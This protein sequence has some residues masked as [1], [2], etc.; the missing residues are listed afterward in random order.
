MVLRGF[1][2]IPR[3]SEGLP[4]GFLPFLQLQIIAAEEIVAV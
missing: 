1:L 3:C 2:D 4:V